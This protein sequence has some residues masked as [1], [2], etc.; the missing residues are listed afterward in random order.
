MEVFM[1]DK[2]KV[3]FNTQ[4]LEQIKKIHNLDPVIETLNDDAAS[5]HSL[6]KSV[7]ATPSKFEGKLDIE[8]FEE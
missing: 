2:I 3:P 6:S 8:G 5:S 1:A 7:S 4:L